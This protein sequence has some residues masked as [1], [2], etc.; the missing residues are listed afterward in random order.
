[1]YQFNGSADWIVSKP[2]HWIFE[3]TGMKKGDRV[4]GL[5][6]WEHHG[7][8]ANIPG[9]E[10]IAEGTT[11]NNSERTSKYAATVYQDLEIIGSLTQRQSFGQWV[12]RNLRGM[13]RRTRTSA[14]LMVS[15]SAFR[16]SLLTFLNAA[17]SPRLI[18]KLTG[19]DLDRGDILINPVR[20][21]TSR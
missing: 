1:M 18:L 9:L 14:G 10:V 7:D 13:C 3:G 21:A 11:I 17:E 6:G 5:V 2:N 20:W 8:P 15:M 12:Y 16:R 4:P 19:F